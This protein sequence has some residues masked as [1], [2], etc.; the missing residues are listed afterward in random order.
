M[1]LRTKRL[2]C[3]KEETIK[4]TLDRKNGFMVGWLA[5]PVER[6]DEHCGVA[7]F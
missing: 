5:G 4:I 1:P 7:E 3:K 6:Q 2:R